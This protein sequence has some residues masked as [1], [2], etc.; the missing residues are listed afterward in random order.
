MNTLKIFSIMVLALALVSTVMA[1]GADMECAGKSKK[2]CKK[3]KK[4]TNCRWVGK[5]GQ[6]KVNGSNYYNL[7]TAKIHVGF[8]LFKYILIHV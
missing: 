7:K 5:K 6:N 4:L 1:G 8:F 2:Q 3:L